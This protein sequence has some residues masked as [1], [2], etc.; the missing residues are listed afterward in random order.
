MLL[1]NKTVLVTGA[2]QG[3]GEAVAVMA[4]ADG[5]AVGVLDLNKDTAASTATAIEAAGGS[6]IAVEMDVTSETGWAD[7]VRAVEEALGP[8]WG[9]VNNAGVTVEHDTVVEIDSETWDYMLGVDLR[10]PWL[11]MKT[12]VPGMI[13]RGGGRIVNISSF[14][15]V[16]GLPNL[17]AYSSAKG[18]VIGLT[19]QAA[20][21]YAKQQ[22]LINAIAPGIIDTPI[23]ANNTP[24][25]TAAFMAATPVGRIGHPDDIAGAAMY[26]LSERSSFTTGQVLTVCGGWSAQ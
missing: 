13:E 23:L 9:L 18:G 10:G 3:I 19:R 14:A 5:A 6:A 15:G 21:Q 4:A 25:M 2:G 16:A 22:V 20:I 8:V 24:E 1:K 26:F 17:A 12:V 11:G 7:A